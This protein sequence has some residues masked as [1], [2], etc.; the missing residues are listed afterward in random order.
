MLVGYGSRKLELVDVFLD[1][2]NPMKE[3]NMRI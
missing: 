3:R 1:F 2:Q